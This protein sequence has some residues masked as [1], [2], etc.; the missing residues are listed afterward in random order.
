M[1]YKGSPTGM[2][3]SLTR[4]FVR[5]G[6]NGSKSWYSLDHYISWAQPFLNDAVVSISLGTTTYIQ[7]VLIHCCASK[8]LVPP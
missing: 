6:T 7:E 2:L 1:Q 8:N 3:V 5:V 4:Q